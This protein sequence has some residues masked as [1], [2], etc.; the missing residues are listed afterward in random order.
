MTPAVLW[1]LVIVGGGSI[2][3]DLGY[4][5]KAACVNAAKT[6]PGACVQYVP[7]SKG[8]TLF[9]K[10]SNKSA[11]SGIRKIPDWGTCQDYLN[12]L[13]PGI[14]AACKPIDIPDNCDVGVS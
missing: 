11:P 12:I 14:P 9:L 4:T 13:R 1:A 7:E 6:R 10:L 2:T 8:G 5:S 3:T